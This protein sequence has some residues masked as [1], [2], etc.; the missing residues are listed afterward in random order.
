MRRRS[1]RVA[2]NAEKAERESDFMQRIMAEDEDGL[3][4]FDAGIKGRGVAADKVFLPGDYVARY[5]GELISHKEALERYRVF[6][7]KCYSHIHFLGM[8]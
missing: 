5:R 2:A 6:H 4:I 8:L 3:R 1:A 7:I